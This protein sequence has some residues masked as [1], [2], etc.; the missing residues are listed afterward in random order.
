MSTRDPLHYPPGIDRIKTGEC[1]ENH[2]LPMACMYCACGHMTECHH[3]MDCEEANCG[4]FLD[5]QQAE[6]Y[7]T[8]DV[9]VP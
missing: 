5:Q 7:Y 3:P 4:H 1:P 6:G 8:E 9:D 2:I